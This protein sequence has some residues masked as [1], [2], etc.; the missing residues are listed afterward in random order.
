MVGTQGQVKWATVAYKS[1]IYDVTHKK[2]AHPK[3]KICFRVRT[4]RLATSFE[5]FTEYVANMYSDTRPEK[6][7]RKATCDPVLLA[8]EFL[9]SAGCDSVKAQS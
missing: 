2:S 7:L 5:P 4:R 9:I 6:F 8:R 1:S 3:Q